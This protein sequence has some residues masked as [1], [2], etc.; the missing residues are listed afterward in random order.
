MENI[1]P[2]GQ[3]PTPSTKLPISPN[4][5]ATPSGDKK[6]STGAEQ[7][8]VGPPTTPPPIKKPL[9]TPP[10]EEKGQKTIQ[11]QAISK[12]PSSGGFVSK[13]KNV[14]L[15]IIIG[16]VVLAIAIIAVGAFYYFSSF[17]KISLTIT[18][19]EQSLDLEIEGK[20]YK[21]VSAPYTI[22]LKS[23]TY[24]INASKEDFFDLEKTIEVNTLEGKQE[25]VFELVE[26]Q[27]ITKI[28]DRE[29]FYPAYNKELASFLFFNR[30]EE[31]YSLSE[32]DLT[33]REETSLATGNIT[34]NIDKVSWSPTYRQVIIKKDNLFQEKDNLLP[35]LE[36]YGEGVKINWSLNLE[37]KDLVNIITKHF[38]PAIKNIS[39]SPEGDR[40]IYFFEN[41]EE[42]TLA[43]STSDGSNFERIVQLKNLAF[44]PDVIWSPDGSRV[45]I[46]ISVGEGKEA[47]EDESDV[48]IY[49]FEE[50]NIIRITDDGL[51]YGALFSP[52]GDKLLYESSNSIRLYDLNKNEAEAALN[53]EIV[54][55]LEKSAWLDNQ[56]FAVLD[57]EGGLWKVNA[58]GERNLFD[59][60]KA[61]MPGNVK[62]IFA[63]DGKIFLISSSGIYELEITKGI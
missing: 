51:S 14:R 56:T 9:V 33:K 41:D 28:F 12:K 47:K 5:E 8:E 16:S 37:R 58:S 4:I 50:R 7:K 54:S 30:N 34:D 31:G 60:K 52:E 53:L 42:R 57:Q 1:N 6:L 36:Q 22:K 19:N 43:V 17:Y 24:K 10:D 38:H 48:Y 29:I 23:G 11:P 46:F 44:D 27:S 20:K 61:T 63:A 25:L 32:Y 18:S 3:K 21:N 35:Y 49:S 62:K 40:I 2:T 39:F 13:K 59:Y 55:S 45:A 26:K 15:L